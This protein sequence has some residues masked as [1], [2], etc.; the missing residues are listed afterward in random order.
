MDSTNQEQFKPSHRPSINLSIINPLSINQANYF[1]DNN[2][3]SLVTNTQQKYE[4]TN[5]LNIFE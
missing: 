1:Q 3:T 2:N 4:S 5:N